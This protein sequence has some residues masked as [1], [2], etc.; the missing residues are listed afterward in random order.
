[1][2]GTPRA[3]A[4]GGP[5]PLGTRSPFVPC[6]GAPSPLPQRPPP[7]CRV[8]SPDSWSWGWGQ[9]RR[10]RKAKSAATPGALRPRP[11]CAPRVGEVR[12]VARTLITELTFERILPAKSYPHTLHAEPGEMRPPLP[13]QANAS[14][15]Q[16]ETQR[17]P[18][19]APGPAHAR[20]RSPCFR[21]A[22]P[23]EG[24][25]LSE[26]AD[27]RRAVPSEL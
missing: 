15:G 2:L 5:T 6:L 17:V 27:P 3:E 23:S 13:P 12:P 9:G 20:P 21:D 19:A 25:A 4:W 16:F 22:F 8:R 18:I 1:M 26:A 14:G 24:L 11:A 10:E 7:S